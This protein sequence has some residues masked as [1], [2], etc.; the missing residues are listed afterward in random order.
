M[1][2][3]A[4]E[5]RLNLLVKTFEEAEKS[6]IKELVDDKGETLVD[7]KG[8]PI[9]MIDY[10]LYKAQRKD[11]KMLKLL[12]GLS[13]WEH[14]RWSSERYIDG[15]ERASE[16]IKKHSSLVP[17]DDP[18]LDEGTKHYDRVNVIKQIKTRLVRYHNRLK[19]N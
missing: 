5:D 1:L 4:L 7:E 2:P 13:I 12:E 9:K 15:W 18:D 19:K 10:D 3:S 8:K 16:G 17:Y 14:D 11:S 6:S